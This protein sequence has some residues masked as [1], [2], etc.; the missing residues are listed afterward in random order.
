ME[1]KDIT[2]SESETEDEELIWTDTEDSESV[3]LDDY[4]DDDEEDLRQGEIEYEKY[5]H[6]LS[7]FIVDDSIEDIKSEGQSSE[8]RV[9]ANKK[10]KIT[11]LK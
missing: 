6:T 8:T 4:E 5:K 9:P 11:D 7:D 3:D 10:R 1:N 2:D